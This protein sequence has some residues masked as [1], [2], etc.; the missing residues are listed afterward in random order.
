LRRERCN[1]A[2]ETLLKGVEMLIGY[3]SESAARGG[4]LA[5]RSIIGQRTIAA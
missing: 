5:T 3:E 2:F 4:P 1:R